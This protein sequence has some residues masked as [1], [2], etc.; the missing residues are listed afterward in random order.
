MKDDQIYDWHLLSY[1]MQKN[2]GL[3]K[4]TEIRVASRPKKVLKDISGR[5]RK[6]PIKSEGDINSNG[7]N[8]CIIF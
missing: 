1:G 6:G 2:G 4:P 7:K 3:K 8:K 5:K